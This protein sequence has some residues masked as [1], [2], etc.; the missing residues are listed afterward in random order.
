MLELV[1][2]VICIVLVL[3]VLKGIFKLAAFIVGVVFLI[4]LVMK[5]IEAGGLDNIV[6]LIQNASMLV[7]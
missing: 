6:G 2:V 4:A 1:V 5:F 3:K 7:S